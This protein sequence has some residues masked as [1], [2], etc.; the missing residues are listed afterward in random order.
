MSS[1]DGKEGSENPKTK[2]SLTK[3]PEMKNPAQLI[4]ICDEHGKE[5]E[6]VGTSEREIPN[7]FCPHGCKLEAGVGRVTNLL[8]EK[9]YGFIETRGD[10]E[11]VFFHFSNLNSAGSVEK[12]D[13]LKFKIG[14][15]H[16]SHRLQAVEVKRE[17]T[18]RR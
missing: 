4:V 8:E 17:P 1:Y 5:M 3:V 15:S 18:Q 6:P 14:Y 9:G 11:N 10:G 12:G 2:I 13:V 16:V 7:Y